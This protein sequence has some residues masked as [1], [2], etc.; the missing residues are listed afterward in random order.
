MK[1]EPASPGDIRGDRFVRDDGQ[2]ALARYQ[3]LKPKRAF[4]TVGIWCD[5]KHSLEAMK[6]AF[7][8]NSNTTT[9]DGT[10][11][12]TGTLVLDSGAFVM[13]GK[14]DELVQLATSLPHKVQKII[15]LSKEDLFQVG[16][17]RVGNKGFFTTKTETLV[18]IAPQRSWWDVFPAGEKRSDI[19]T[20]AGWRA[21]LGNRDIPVAPGK[22]LEMSTLA[23]W[24]PQADREPWVWVNKDEYW[25]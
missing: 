8:R 7:E 25:I 5:P 22:S 24:L 4:K 9:S 14:T 1:K 18:I 11:V 13:A 2:F 16:Y 19:H 20:D 6:V 12:Q 23:S 17:A 3:T 10:L 21:F 15:T